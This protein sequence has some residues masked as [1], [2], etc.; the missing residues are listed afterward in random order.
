[1]GGA[2]AGREPVRDVVRGSRSAGRPAARSP[3]AGPSPAA[4]PDPRASVLTK[5]SL[6]PLVVCSPSQ[7]PLAVL[8]SGPAGGAGARGLRAETPVSPTDPGGRGAP[9]A[10][11]DGSRLRLVSS[12]ACFGSLA[13]GG[14]ISLR[15]PPG[16]KLF[17]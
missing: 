8:G 7:T 17:M 11:A 13:I 12:F 4:S 15:A 16:W 5:P 6:P 2:R 3:P 14:G 10:A 9:S 1:M